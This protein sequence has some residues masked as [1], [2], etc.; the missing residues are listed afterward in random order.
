MLACTIELLSGYSKDITELDLANKDINGS[1]GFIN[2]NSLIKLNCTYTKITSLNNLPNNL[3]ELY[4]SYNEI[5]SLEY[6]KKSN[7][8]LKIIN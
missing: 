2:F 1:L 8:K 6:I 4:C 7:P 3:I 5:T